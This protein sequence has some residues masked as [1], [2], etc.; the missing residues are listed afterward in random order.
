MNLWITK[1]GKLFLLYHFFGAD[2]KIN[3]YQSFGITSYVTSISTI[4]IAEVHSRGKGL[5]DAQF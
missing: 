5:S 2:L 1:I 3:G 4:K